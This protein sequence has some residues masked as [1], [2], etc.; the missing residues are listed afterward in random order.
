MTQPTVSKHWRKIGPWIRLQFHLV[1]PTV[2]TIIQHI[3]SIKQKHTKYTYTIETNKSTHSEMGPM[4]QNPIQRT[5]KT[6]HLSVLMLPEIWAHS[7]P[8]LF[9]NSRSASV[10]R[11]KPL[12]CTAVERRGCYFAAIFDCTCKWTTVEKWEVCSVP[13]RWRDF[14][15]H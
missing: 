8:V 5:V 11:E 2:L 13:V 15:P 12:L 7:K 10:S 1:H 14:F 6:A 4:W 9:K 3:C